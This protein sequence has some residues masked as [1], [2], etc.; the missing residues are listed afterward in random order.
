MSLAAVLLIW[1]P[2]LG[3]VVKSG[4]GP[5]VPES[6]LARFCVFLSDPELKFVKKRTLIRSH[7]SILAVVGVCQRWALDWTWI[8]LDPDYSEFS[9]IC[10]GAGVKRNFWLAKFLTS[11]HV[12]M[13][14]VIFYIPNA[15]IKLII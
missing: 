4:H 13:H 10:I 8:G 12:R 9:C 11:H 14:R 1:Q 3:S 5:G 2:C 7:F 6:T 15:L